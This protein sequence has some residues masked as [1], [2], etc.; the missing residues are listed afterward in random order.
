MNEITSYDIIRHSQTRP[1]IGR[2]RQKVKLNTP[3]VKLKL[4]SKPLLQR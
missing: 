3:V 2:V 4:G 1:M